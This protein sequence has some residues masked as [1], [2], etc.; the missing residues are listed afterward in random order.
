MGQQ[1][2]E[3]YIG[4]HNSWKIYKVNKNTDRYM[5]QYK[6]YGQAYKEIELWNNI[7]DKNTLKHT[8]GNRTM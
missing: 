1:N 2:M 4:K 3:I 5:G 6:Y 7:K 8:F